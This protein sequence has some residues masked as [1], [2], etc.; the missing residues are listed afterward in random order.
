[1]IPGEAKRMF[2]GEAKRMLPGDAIRIFYFFP[3]RPGVAVP[4]YYLPLVFTA[5]SCT[6]VVG[7]SSFCGLCLCCM[8]RVYVAIKLVQGDALFDERP[9]LLSTWLSFLCSS[10]F[11]FRLLRSSLAVRCLSYAHFGCALTSLQV[12]WAGA[13][14][15]FCWGMGSGSL[16]IPCMCW[17]TACACSVP[18]GYALIMVSGRGSFAV[19]QISTLGLGLLCARGFAVGRRHYSLLKLVLSLVPEAFPCVI[20][21]VPAIAIGA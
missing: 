5:P 15:A 16:A 21:G 19:W 8:E 14:L 3:A 7:F 17:C 10:L 4:L 20:T 11:Q 2:P 1:M 12:L 9:K 18:L 6:G 13:C